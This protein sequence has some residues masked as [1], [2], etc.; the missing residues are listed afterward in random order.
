MASE[1]IA[2][3][4]FQKSARILVVDDEA[5]ARTALVHLLTDEGFEVFEAADGYKALGQLKDVSPDILLT[6]LKMPLMDG[7]TL[8]KK[9]RELQPDL[10]SIVMTAF[11]SVETAIEAMKAGADDYL[12]KPLN[13]D[14]VE[15][16]IARNLERLDM[17]RE[18]ER[19]RSEK[20]APKSK[21]IG[22]SAPVQD[23]LRLIEQIA[24]SR[25]T[26]LVTGES[27]TGKEMVARQIHELSNRA[28]KPFMTIHCAA[29]P[30]TL[31]ESELFGHE[32]GSF[33]GANAT[34]RGRF[35]EADGGTIFLDEIGEVSPSTQVK[36][37][38]F[39]QTK[40][41]ERVGGNQTRTVDV[42]IVTAT[43]R[44]LEDEVANGT[45]RE[46]LYYRLNV[47][48][49]NAPPMRSRRSDILL[50]VRHF[51][52]VY[53]KE[54]GKDISD[55]HPDVMS[56]LENHDWPGNVRELQNVVERAV[57]LCPGKT[58]L[59]E[60]LPSSFS[61]RLLGTRRFGMDVR[62]PGST[63]GDLEKYAI[64]TTYESTGGDSAETA[65]ILGISQRKVQYKLRD[66]KE[67]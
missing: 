60:H 3:T 37:L 7:V 6:D 8:L 22:S 42:R 52:D 43:N 23:M 16:T 29:L 45:F 62:I 38:R 20:P 19:L 27:G 32:K 4:D 24:P 10:V 59:T 53:S 17:R 58:I 50:L 11:A 26:V 49:V 44:N 64:L 41:F 15:L 33:T 63:L 67:E 55:I 39:L 65:R 30:E 25:A 51:V 46:D 56:I 48:N 66:Y 47:I 5:G 1:P 2:V 14:A 40:E 9:A 61:S 12:T 31:L 54:N 36:L 21:I 35:E 28:D 57:V 18:L 13:F 34:R